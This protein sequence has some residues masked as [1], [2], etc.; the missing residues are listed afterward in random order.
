MCR[1][2]VF[3]P[4]ALGQFDES[5]SAVVHAGWKAEAIHLQTEAE[6]FGA[7]PVVPAVAVLGQVR[8]MKLLEVGMKCFTAAPCQIVSCC[9]RAKL[10]KTRVVKCE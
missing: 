4:L 1:L 6:T 5:S 8:S 9:E 10:Q 7:H 3:M 2:L